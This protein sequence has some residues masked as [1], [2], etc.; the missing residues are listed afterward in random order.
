M[1]YETDR[2]ANFRLEPLTRVI[3]TAI[4]NEGSAR[5]LHGLTGIV[6]GDHPIAAGW[7]LVQI[8]PNER[9]DKHLWPIPWNR[10]RPI[11]SKRFHAA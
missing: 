6:L 11:R 9:T 8:D 7:A 5:L 10:L 3:V 1:E 2:L 4:K